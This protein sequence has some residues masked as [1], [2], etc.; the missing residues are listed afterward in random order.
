M[1]NFSTDNFSSFHVIILKRQRLQCS[2][3]HFNSAN[4]LFEDSSQCLSGSEDSSRAKIYMYLARLL[5]SAGRF[6]A[7]KHLLPCLLESYQA[8]GDDEAFSLAH[9]TIALLSDPT[10]RGSQKSLVPQEDR[11][12]NDL[13]G[14]AT[15][16]QEDSLQL[17]DNLELDDSRGGDKAKVSTKLQEWAAL[18]LAYVESRDDAAKEC[19]VCGMGHF[20][21]K[22][23]RQ[24]DQC[25]SI[26]DSFL[27][28]V[29]KA[30]NPAEAASVRLCGKQA[31]QQ[32]G[33]SYLF[34]SSDACVPLQHHAANQAFAILLL[35][36]QLKPLARTSEFVSIFQL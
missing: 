13:Q 34:P 12:R 14:S 31:L 4:N 23:L 11:Y 28:T 7:P 33:Q 32:S 24:G 25:S 16:I 20:I 18:D 15:E 3:V 19:I 21:A 26:L 2:I 29:Q 27:S 5:M 36:V 17:I 6:E 22:L 1:L 10:S 8:S 30:C 35:S 9:L